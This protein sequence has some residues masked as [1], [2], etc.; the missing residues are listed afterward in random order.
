MQPLNLQVW[1]RWLFSDES[2]GKL[3]KR[4]FFTGI[5]TLE[6]EIRPAGEKVY[7]HTAIPYG[8]YPVVLTWSNRFG[9]IMP[10]IDNVPGFTGIRIH[11]GVTNRDTA[12]CLLVGTGIQDKKL[13]GSIPA[14][15]FVFSELENAKAKGQKTFI[16]FLSTD[17]W[18]VRQAL[19]IFTLVLLAIIFA[20]LYLKYTK[21]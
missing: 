19:I 11:S 12:G 14:F 6:D 10:L 5:Y 4:N 3:Y 9:R 15:N 20:L 2:L 17:L 16:E 1:R 21:K 13:T 8:K 18:L 7:G